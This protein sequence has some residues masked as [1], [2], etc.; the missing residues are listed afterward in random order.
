MSLSFLAPV[1]FETE[2]IVF[3]GLKQVG[4]PAELMVSLTSI[5]NLS[6]SGCDIPELCMFLCSKLSILKKRYIPFPLVPNICLVL[7][8]YCSKLSL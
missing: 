2:Y 6:N 1:V 4:I 3:A 5:P 7:E 8:A